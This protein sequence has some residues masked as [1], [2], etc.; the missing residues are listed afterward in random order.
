MAANCVGSGGGPVSE[1]AGRMVPCDDI[2]TAS[3]LRSSGPVPKGRAAKLQKVR[4]EHRSAGACAR[5]ASPPR[6]DQQRLRQTGGEATG[7]HPRDFR[8]ICSRFAAYWKRANGE[9]AWMALAQAALGLAGRQTDA[10]RHGIGT[11]HSRLRA[12]FGRR[13]GQT[14]RLEALPICYRP[15][16]Q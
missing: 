4:S 8:A 13:A 1:P 14:R 9:T 5:I 10:I 2:G 16:D 15:R 11:S 12:R 3:L 6:L 7:K